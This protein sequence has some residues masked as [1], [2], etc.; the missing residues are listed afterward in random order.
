VV[1]NV[2][3]KA[4]DDL[5]FIRDAMERASAFTAVPGWGGALMGVSALATE[6]AAGREV[7]P[8]WVAAWLIDA[9]LAAAIGLAGTILKAQRSSVPLGAPATR[10][11]ALAFVPALLAGAVLTIAFV[12]RGALEWLPGSWLL[13]YGAAVTS[14]GALS[15]AAVPVM[16]IGFMILGGV[17][18][19]GPGAGPALMAVGFGGLHIGFGVIIGVKYGG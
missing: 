13:L 19:A 10:R 15:V 7:S 12:A 17:A 14:G 18:L 3:E 2:K 9:A 11:F 16:G 1:Y 8:R 6:V 4:A 5:R